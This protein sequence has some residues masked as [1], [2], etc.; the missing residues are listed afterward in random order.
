MYRPLDLVQIKTTKRVRFRSGPPGQAADPH[1]NWSFVGYVE[2]EALI[3]KDSTV[4]RIPIEDLQPVASL[5]TEKLFEALNEIDLK[6]R[7]Y[8]VVEHIAKVFDV[9]A[10]R[11]K[12]ILHQHNLPTYVGSAAELDQITARIKRDT[13]GQEERRRTGRS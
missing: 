11:A 9:D 4:V 12:H 3:A 13:H 2:N 1:G 5:S 6:G 8:S 7:M 10:G